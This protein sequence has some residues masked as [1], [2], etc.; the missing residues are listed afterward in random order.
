ML[1]RRSAGRTTGTRRSNLTTP[2]GPGVGQRALSDFEAIT[3]EPATRD[4]EPATRGAEPA[5]RGAGLQTSAISQMQLKVPAIPA[6]CVFEKLATT[7]RI[8]IVV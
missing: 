7:D 3:D 5:T 6:V 2:Y 8:T 1:Q 4:A